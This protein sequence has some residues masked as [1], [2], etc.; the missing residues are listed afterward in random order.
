MKTAFF[1]GHRDAPNDIFVVLYKTIMQQIENFNVREFIV[2]RYGDF[3]RMAARAV[4][5]AKKR[6]A[7]IT[8]TLLLPYHP[9]ER[10][11]E[12]PEGF[13]NS[14]YFEGMERVPRRAAIICANHRMAMDCDVLIAYVTRP[15]GNAWDLL[16]Y[17]KKRKDVHIVNLAKQRI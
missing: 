4:I 6:H 17:V 15:L 7:N 13:D 14:I 9:A 11:M 12:L 2:G 1:I 3:D 8:L 5:A 10:P 16:E